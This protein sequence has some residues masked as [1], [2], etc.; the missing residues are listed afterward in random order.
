MPLAIMERIDG[1]WDGLDCRR[2]FPPLTE[3]ESFFY[4]GGDGQE[5]MPD[6]VGGTTHTALAAPFRVGVARGRTPVAG[7]LV[8]FRV[9]DNQ[10]RGRLAPGPDMDPATW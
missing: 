4:L 10:R 3:L 8:R 1:G 6:L 2:V 9:L 7:R 5:A